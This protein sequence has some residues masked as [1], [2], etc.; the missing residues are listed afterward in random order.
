MAYK[1]LLLIIVDTKTSTMTWR[2][3]YEYNQRFSI[4]LNGLFRGHLILI[5]VSYLSSAIPELMD[6]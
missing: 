4:Y 5:E 2:D 1:H 6:E 3:A